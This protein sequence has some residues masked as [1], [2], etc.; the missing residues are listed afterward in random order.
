MSIEKWCDLCPLDAHMRECEKRI[1]E[2]EAERDALRADCAILESVANKLC[3]CADERALL[4]KVAEAAGRLTADLSDL[5][6]RYSGLSLNSD[7]VV[8]PWNELLISGTFG[9][10]WFHSLNDAEQS[11][12]TWRNSREK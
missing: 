10:E 3:K 9:E 2:L 11:L 6:E 8:A 7:V 4:R 5:I 1:D 12:I